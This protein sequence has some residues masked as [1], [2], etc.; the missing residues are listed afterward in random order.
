[1]LCGAGKVEGVC[2]SDIGVLGGV[3]ENGFKAGHYSFV[4]RKKDDQLSLAIMLELL[5]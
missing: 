1:M 5:C 2:G 3:A 4:E